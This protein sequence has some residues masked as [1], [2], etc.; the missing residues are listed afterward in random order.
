MIAALAVSSAL[1][2]APASALHSTSSITATVHATSAVS[3]SAFSRRELFSNSAAAALAAAPLAA[4]ADGAAS[5]QQL[6]RSRQIYGSR[7]FRLQGATADAILEEKNCF[8]LFYSGA[9]RSAADKDTVKQLKAV[10]KTILAAASTGDS[11]AAQAG[12]KEFVKLG[13]IQELDT[14]PGGNFNPKQ[15]RNTGAPMTTEIE[16]LM[17]TQ[18]FALYK[19]VNK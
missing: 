3:M 13:K 7:V 2:F 17:G 9:Y 16:A 12:V 6:Q 19:P 14:I 4:M 10:E 15:R 1:A 5:A 18:S 8:Q 11:T